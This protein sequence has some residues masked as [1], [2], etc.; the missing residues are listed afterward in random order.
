MARDH[1]FRGC[2]K[3][4]KGDDLILDHDPLKLMISKAHD[5][6]CPKDL[7]LYSTKEIDSA[8]IVLEI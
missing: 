1:Y 4:R 2:P 3:E 6:T 5:L 7:A 8:H